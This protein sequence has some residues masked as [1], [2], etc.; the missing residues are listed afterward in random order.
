MPATLPLRLNQ[1]CSQRSATAFLALGVPLALLA[2]VAVVAIA[3]EAVLM[4]E[5][6]ALLQQ[7]PTLALEILAAVG[8]LIYLVVLPSRRLLA[9]LTTTRT[10]DIANGVVTVNEG[11]HFRKWSWSA[12]LGSYCGVAHNVRASLSGSRHEI[13]LLHPEREKSIL[14]CVAPRTSQAEVERTATLLGHKQ[15]ASSELY[16]FK[17]LWPRISTQPLPEATH[18]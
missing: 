5:A 6:R 2:L 11:S 15:I 18:A 14:L 12:P 9:R 13:I 16:R 3:R 7:R 4:P 8:F 1:A 17:G 10:V